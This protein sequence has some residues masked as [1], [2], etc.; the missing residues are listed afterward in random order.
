MNDQAK[1]AAARD[2]AKRRRA[3]FIA[4]GIIVLMFAGV[5]IKI[6]FGG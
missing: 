2:R 3:D 5:A 6:F 1:R 4:A